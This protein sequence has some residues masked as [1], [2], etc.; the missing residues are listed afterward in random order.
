MDEKLAG[1]YIIGARSISGSVAQLMPEGLVPLL[2]GVARWLPCDARPAARRDGSFWSSP[3]LYPQ[4]SSA[5]HASGRMS[6]GMASSYINIAVM[7]VDGL[8]TLTWNE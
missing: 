6:V 2:A 7:P 3:G 4:V 1:L 8:K 5:R